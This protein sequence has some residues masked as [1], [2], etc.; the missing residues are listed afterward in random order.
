MEQ[1]N[2]K[3]IEALLEGAQKAGADAADAALATGEALSVSV[4]LGK[5]ESVERSE[6]FAAGLR[7]FVGQKVATLS[8]GQLS[9]DNIP[10]LAERAVAMAKASPDD[11]YA[12][13]AR[14]DQIATDLPDLDM[15]D[16]TDLG[17]EKLTEMAHAT[18]ETARAA[19]GITNS[20]G[21]SA[22][23]AHSHIYIAGTHGFSAGYS[24]SSF[25]FSTVV[26]AEKDGEMQRDYDY[27]SAVYASDLRDPEAVGEMAAKR[28]LARLG[29]RKALTG[30]YPVIYDNRVSRSLAGH[31][32]SAINGASIA[33]GTSM[34]KDKMGEAIASSSITL[35][36]DPLR[37]R[38]AG[39]RAFDGDALAVSKQTLIDKGVLQSWL[40]DLSSAAQLG[41]AKRSLA[42]PPS[43]G[44]SN[45]ILENGTHS[46][47]D[48]I[49]GIEQGFFITELMGSSVSLITGDYSRGAGGFWIENGEITWPV[50]E[51]TIAGNLKDIFTNLT[52][53]NDPDTTSSVIAPSL[54]VDQMMVAGS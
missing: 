30:N 54:Y 20:E 46:L 17:P 23:Q 21:G 26:L 12:I 3:L 48:L 27:S 18:E 41:N 47:D 14:P 1:T 34:F 15:F 42:N 9:E 35:I 49:S 50:G 24:R 31:F 16:E 52:P 44:T 22:S 43:P 2:Q 6:D 8:I 11:P 39:S 10:E 28:T 7:V 51:A 19:S 40:L 32:A 36:D 13:L 33:R 5:T 29:S 37:R 45:L 25:G 53:A 38:G 4:R